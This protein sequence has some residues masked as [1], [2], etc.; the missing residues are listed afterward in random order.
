[1]FGFFDSILVRIICKMLMK[2]VLFPFIIMV[3]LIFGCWSHLSGYFQNSI[4]AIFSLFDI[5]SLTSIISIIFLISF[6]Y[7]SLFV[8]TVRT[9]C[10][11]VIFIIQLS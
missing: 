11:K 2:K 1:M 3:D 10:L 6:D 9:F 5:E 4:V 7:F 8:S